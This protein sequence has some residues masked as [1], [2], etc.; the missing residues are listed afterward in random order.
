[1][2]QPMSFP[3]RG[4]SQNDVLRMLTEKLCKNIPPEQNFCNPYAGPPHP[5]TRMAWELAQNSFFVSGWG[6]EIYRGTHEMEMEAVRM[7]SSLLNL[8]DEKSLGFI[9]SGGTESNLLA[10]RTAKLLAERRKK[11]SRP[12]I[13]MPYSGHFS[14][15]LAGN[16]FGI[17]VR[18]IELNDD[19]TPKMDQVE[20]LINENTIAVVCSAPEGTLQVMDPI[21]EFAE[22]AERK[23]VYLHVDAAFGGFLFPFMKDLGYSVPAFDFSL[24]SVCSMMTDSHKLGLVPIAASF[25]IFRENYVFDDIPTEHVTIHTITSTKNGGL[26]AAAWGLFQLLGREGYRKYLQNALEIANALARGI[27][28]IQGV[29]L[30][31]PNKQLY[32]VLGF[33]T[34]D[35]TPVENLYKEILSRRWGVGLERTPGPRGMPFIRISLSPMREKRYAEGFIGALE[36]SVRAARSKA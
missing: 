9:T 24:P 19:L 25:V 18:E 28:G 35:R 15:R 6:E 21:K 2:P 14:F 11:T 4:I 26:A 17:R 5:F 33:T 31:A 12:E 8:D 36:E 32:T 16:L 10:M 30:L 29:K 13:V 22:I 3:E 34:T 23:N 27:S 1:M 20:S 7:V